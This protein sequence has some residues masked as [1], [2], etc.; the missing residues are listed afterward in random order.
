MT[1]YVRVHDLNAFKVRYFKKGSSRFVFRNLNF[2]LANALRLTLKMR[3]ST[4]TFGISS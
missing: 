3:S 4:P 2:K 1:K